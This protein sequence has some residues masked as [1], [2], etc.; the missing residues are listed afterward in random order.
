MANIPNV[1][2][3]GNENVN[4]AGQ[5]GLRLPHRVTSA[6]NRPVLLLL[7]SD[8][9]RDSEAANIVECPS[10]RRSGLKLAFVMLIWLQ[11][12]F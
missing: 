10:D 6:W 8:H 9:S 7:D 4:I 1:A 5:S 11:A 2:N 12:R 3:V